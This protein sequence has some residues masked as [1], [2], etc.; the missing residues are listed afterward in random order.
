MDGPHHA[1]SQVTASETQDLTEGFADDLLA[2]LEQERQDLGIPGLAVV[3]VAEG[4]VVVEA[5]LGSADD[6]GTPVDAQTPFLL[7]SLAKSVTAIAV[8]RLVEAGLVD[9]EEPVSTY[10]PEL[11]RASEAVTVA[12]L[13][14]HRGGLSVEDGIEPLVAGA[15]ASLE[16]VASG[17]A[18]ELH[19]AG[20]EY[21]NAGYDLLALLVER[22][23]GSDFESYLQEHI[24]GPWDMTRT[25][26]D[27]ERALAEGLATGHDHWLLLGYRPHRP[28]LPEGMVGSY[29]MF[30]TAHDLGRY[31]N[32]HLGMSD[33]AGVLGPEARRSLHMGESAGEHS[34]YA[35]GLFVLPAD[36]DLVPEQPLRARTTLIHDGSAIGY[37]SVLWM[38]PE[39]DIGLALLANANDQADE[40]QL[41]RVAFNVQRLLLDIPLQPSQPPPDLLYRWGKH[42]LAAL[43]LAQLVCTAA[44]V[45]ALRRRRSGAGSRGGLILLAATVALGI[46]AMILTGLVLPSA[47]RTPFRVLLLAPDLRVMIVTGWVLAGIAA[48][49]VVW[50]WVPR[51]SLDAGADVLGRTGGQVG[52]DRDRGGIRGQR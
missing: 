16:Q 37:R 22:Q 33:P 36:P 47:V 31:L 35:G 15:G 48:V 42:G 26:T 50:W 8:M 10:L 24:F 51:R 3:L 5:G 32:G 13:L 28:P 11:T 44:L 25:T 27:P 7:A 43:V 40:Q 29:R 49:I 21:S 9:L 39:E 41:V 23:S 2:Y 6:S 52:L 1:R 34:A 46:V 12:D 18:E 17:V 4:E 20:F 19:P 14:H 38:W 45:P 30:S